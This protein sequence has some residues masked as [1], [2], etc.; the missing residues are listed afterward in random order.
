MKFSE[1]PFSE[2]SIIKCGNHSKRPATAHQP[3]EQRHSYVYYWTV[4]CETIVRNGV[5]QFW[6]NV[7]GYGSVSTKHA[8]A[9]YRNALR[10]AGYEEIAPPA[11]VRY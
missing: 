6:A 2:K 8:V 1:M 7:N 10:N 3:D 4:I 9:M 11:W 5:K